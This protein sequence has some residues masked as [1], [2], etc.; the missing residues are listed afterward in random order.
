M[1]ITSIKYINMDKDHEKRFL[2]EKVLNRHTYPIH[3]ISGVAYSQSPDSYQN[4]M[5][6][7]VASYVV[8]DS[9][10]RQN[11][12]IGCWIAHIKALESVIETDGYTVVVE[13]DFVCKDNFFEEALTMLNSADIDLDV[14]IFDPKGDGP[15]P[16]HLIQ[17]RIYHSQGESFPLYAGSHCVFY[18]NCKIKSL[19]KTIESSEIRDYDG[20]LLCNPNIKTYLFYTGQSRTI[21]FYSDIEDFQIENSLWRGIEEWITY[22]CN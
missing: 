16:D 1:E 15:H 2:L 19:L 5:L 6:N 22:M 12:V 10:K 4:Y 13:D 9:L 18:K 20:Y 8:N 3:R 17:D 11:G 7:G 14:A 21:Y